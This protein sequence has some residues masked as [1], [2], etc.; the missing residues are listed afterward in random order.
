MAGKQIKI[1]SKIEN[2]EG[3]D[4]FDDILAVTDGPMQAPHTAHCPHRAPPSL[5]ALLTPC[6][7]R[8]AQA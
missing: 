4:R 2:Q 5:G 3:L 8:V 6:T 7:V 1:I